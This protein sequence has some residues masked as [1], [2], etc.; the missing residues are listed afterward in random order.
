MFCQ[1]S[2]ANKMMNVRYCLLQSQ[3]IQLYNQCLQL[4]LHYADEFEN[5]AL[6]LRLS[7]P[8][9]LIHRK[10]TELFENTFQTAG[11]W[12][13][14]LLISV[15]KKTFSQRSFSNTM[16]MIMTVVSMAECFFF[17]KSKMSGDWWVFKFLQRSAIRKQLMLFQGTASVLKFLRHNLDGVLIHA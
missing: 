16:A 4:L 11:M 2:A 6:F 14:R 7:L 8:S 1:K 12:K 13:R 10:P 9:T 17:H 5:A 15:W 3:F